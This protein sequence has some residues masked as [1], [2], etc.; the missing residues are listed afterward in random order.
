MKR[1]LIET[2]RLQII[3]LTHGQLINYLQTDGSLEEQLNI[4]PNKRKI[5]PALIEAFEKIILPSVGNPSKNYLFSTLWTII[6]KEKKVMVGDICFKG[7]PNANGE[8]EIGYGTYPQFQKMG[9][10]TE[11]VGALSQWAF[12]QARVACILA[13]THNINFASQKILEKNG[14]APFEKKEGAIWWRLQKV[15]GLAVERA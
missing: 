7:E 9:Y 1:P 2:E 10:M 15:E 13:E 4:R 6:D 8:V 12:E 14:F 3:P 5:S 11:A